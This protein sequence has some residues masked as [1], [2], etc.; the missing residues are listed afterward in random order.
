MRLGG[1][2]IHGN[3]LDTLGECLSAL[4][5]LCDEVV[6]IDSGSTD[7]SSALVKSSGAR[8]IRQP[9]RGFGSARATAVR[10]LPHVDYVFFLDSDEWV[11]DHSKELLKHWRRSNPTQPIYT[12]QRHDHVTVGTSRFRYRSQRRARLVRKDAATWTQAMIVHEALPRSTTRVSTAISIEHH[13]V[14]SLDA[15]LEKDHLYAL[16]W[17][18]Q[19]SGSGR[20]S[21]PPTAKRAAHFLSDVLLRG[22]GFRGGISGVKVAWEVSRYHSLKYEYLREV[23]RGKYSPLVDAFNAGAIDQLL[24]LATLVVKSKFSPPPM[25]PG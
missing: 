16:L 21:K 11:T 22:V 17:A 1:F 7:G 15:R 2:V 13:F 18:V 9:W 19:S 23:S 4:C 5:E 24:G 25:S 20:R 14:R 12:V 10:E 6:A 8:A 3:N